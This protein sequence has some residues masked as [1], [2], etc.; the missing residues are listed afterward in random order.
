M[1]GAVG[2]PFLRERN[3]GLAEMTEIR[4]PHMHGQNFAAVV[5]QMPPADDCTRV[6]EIF[7]LLGDGTRLRLLW[8]LCHGCECVSNLAA[9]MAMSNAAVSHHLQL[10]RR[11]G[12]II[13][14]RTGK[15]IYYTLAD[16]LEARLIHQAIDEMFRI[17]CPNRREG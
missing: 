10:L 7:R 16:T 5:A 3:R 8:L 12:L 13:S 17:K 1:L 2:K 15:E 4:L 11:S 14:Q 9:A 6:A